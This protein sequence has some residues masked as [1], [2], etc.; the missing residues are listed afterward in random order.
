MK[1]GIIKGFSEDCFEYVQGRGLDF[2]EVC[3][4]FDNE[5]QMFIEK[6]D[7]TKALVEKYGV[8][9]LS[10][11]RWNAEPIKDGKLNRESIDMVKTQIAAAAYIGSP[12]FNLGVNRDES[13]TLYKNYVLAAEYLREITEWGK[14]HGITIALYNCGWG[15]FLNEDKAWEIILPEF[16]ELMLKYDCSHT[17]GRDANYLWELDKWADRV[18]HMHVK[19]T[20][21]IGHRYV[22]DPPA[23][24]D[25]LDWRS[26]FAVLY[27]HGYD[28]TLSIEPHSAVWNGELGERG[29]DYTVKFIRELM[30]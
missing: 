16:P 24:I 8:P 19:G 26:I 13:I 29:I 10:V 20:I 7:E 2:I 14:E 12:V 5:T 15:N 6:K 27:A 28:K 9:V 23:G 25:S 18:A 30:V 21:K 4:N 11:G 1:L 3:S 17:Y 22:D